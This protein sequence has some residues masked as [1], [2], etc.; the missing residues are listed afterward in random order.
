MVNHT[1]L[2]IRPLQPTDDRAAFHSGDV[3]LDRFF[4]CFAGQ[5]QF[6]HH[7]GTTYVAVSSERIHGF[8]TVS[9]G[10]LAATSVKK[11]TRANLPGYPLPILRLSRLA[12]DQ[13][14]RGKGVGRLLLRT[15][16]GLALDLRDRLG[17]TGI[18]VDAKP[19]ALGFYEV[20]GF[21][22]LDSETGGLKDRPVPMPL[23][24][25]VQAIADA[26]GP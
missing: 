22:R 12:V 21:L 26:L 14:D 16:L 13:R 24:L 9:P 11:A 6:R 5:N 10:E 23:F 7:I 3:D 18:V 15:A 19:N 20:L 8:V 25:P 2:L 4:H 17:C 1:D